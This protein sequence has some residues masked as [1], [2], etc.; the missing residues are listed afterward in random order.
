MHTVV[1][2]PLAHR[3]VLHT[4]WICR[5]LLRATHQANQPN[6]MQSSDTTHQPRAHTQ[7]MIISNKPAAHLDLRD[8]SWCGEDA[9]EVKLAKQH[10]V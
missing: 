1:V 10:V 6:S 7:V 3:N 9:Q 2:S 4:S 8:A 5:G